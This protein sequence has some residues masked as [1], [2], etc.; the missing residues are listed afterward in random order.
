VKIQYFV[1]HLGPFNGTPVENHCE[2]GNFASLENKKEETKKGN[3]FY[4]FQLNARTVFP[5][6]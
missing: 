6:Y 2:R 3:F 4:N 5:R 1:A